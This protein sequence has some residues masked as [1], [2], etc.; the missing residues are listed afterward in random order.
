M[1]SLNEATCAANSKQNISQTLCKKVL[2]S[3][4]RASQHVFNKGET[5]M[6][7]CSLLV[8]I[9]ATQSMMNCN[10]NRL[11][12]RL[13]AFVCLYSCLYCYCLIPRLTECRNPTQ[14]WLIRFSRTILLFWTGKKKGRLG[15]LSVFSYQESAC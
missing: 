4:D 13:T 2:M 3:Q 10:K 9:M 8:Y 12:H 1:Q 7:M 14:L 5:N 11:P 6:S 15:C